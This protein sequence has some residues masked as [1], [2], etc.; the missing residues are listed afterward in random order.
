MQRAVERNSETRSKY[1][2]CAV[3]PSR[4]SPSFSNAALP[5][6]VETIATLT[7]SLLEIASYNAEGPT[8]R[9]S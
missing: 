4:I 2:M 1:A 7:T 3:S 6:V 9:M 5:E 8:I